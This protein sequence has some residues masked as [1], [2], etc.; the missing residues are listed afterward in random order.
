MASLL[1]S[2]E[3]RPPGQRMHGG[4]KLLSSWYIKEERGERKE[5]E[6]GKDGEEKREGT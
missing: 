3:D 6:E 2:K 5:K 1:E 4:T